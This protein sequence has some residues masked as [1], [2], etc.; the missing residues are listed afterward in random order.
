MAAKNFNLEQIKKIDAKIQLTVFGIIRRYQRQ[1]I[2]NKSHQNIPDLITYIIVFYYHKLTQ[3]LVRLDE[4]FACAINKDEWSVFEDNDGCIYHA[5]MMQTNISFNTSK[6]YTL[7]IAK[8][9]NF[10][11]YKCYFRWRRFGEKGQ[12]KTIDGS[13]EKCIAEFKNKFR[14]K[15][16]NEW[17]E[18][19]QFVQQNRKYSYIPIDDERNGEYCVR[20]RHTG[21][22]KIN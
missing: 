11:E 7:Q 6:M 13:K 12:S 8:K 22:S 10:E 17:V 14:A 15:T 2:H 16:G 9:N 4:Y 19:E 21:K 20:R 1:P 18:R 3:P 5:L